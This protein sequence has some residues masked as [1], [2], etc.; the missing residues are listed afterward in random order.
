[1]ITF[2]L[3]NDALQSCTPFYLT[4]EINEDEEWAFALRDGC[5]DQ[6]GD[7]FDE[8]SDVHDYIINDSGCAEFLAEHTN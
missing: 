6:H 2:D 4:K 5:G 3:L 8:L 7:L 1:M